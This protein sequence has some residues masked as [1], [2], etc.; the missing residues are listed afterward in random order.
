MKAERRLSTKGSLK[1][2]QQNWE[3]QW[4]RAVSKEN[5]QTINKENVNCL[6]HE[7]LNINFKC[8]WLFYYAKLQCN[9]AHCGTAESLLLQQ[10][11]I[12]CMRI[13]WE[14]HSCF[15]DVSVCYLF[16]LDGLGSFFTGMLS[17]FSYPTSSLWLFPY[18]F[19][20]SDP[21][22]FHVDI[23]Q[24]GVFKWADTMASAFPCLV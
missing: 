10:D 3:G 12:R 5:I 6:L 19:S 21:S 13:I 2:K 14:H 22:A 4:G 7:F 17:A 23:R 24:S 20:N 8:I 18:L 9:K 16:V 15:L 11:T 1:G